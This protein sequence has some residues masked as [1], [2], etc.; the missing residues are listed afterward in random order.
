M[1]AGSV[2]AEEQR[3]GEGTRM[4]RPRVG[5]LRGGQRG[6]IVLWRKYC[7]VRT[8]CVYSIVVARTEL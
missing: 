7:K 3:L 1:A 5:R 6:W 8:E 4:G 2:R